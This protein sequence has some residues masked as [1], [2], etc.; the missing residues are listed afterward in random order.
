MHICANIQLLYEHLSII[1]QEQRYIRDLRR[2]MQRLGTLASTDPAFDSGLY[3]EMQ[4]RAERLEDAI[5][6]RRSLVQM[7]CEELL[8][9]RQYIE[10]E[11]NEAEAAVQKLFWE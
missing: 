5:S 4:S 2:E 7:M 11:I 9:S 3:L 1:E 6:D 10:Q 8:A